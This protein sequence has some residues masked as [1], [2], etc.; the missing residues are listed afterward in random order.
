MLTSRRTLVAALV[1]LAVG[2]AGLPA[3]ASADTSSR[4]VQHKLCVKIFDATKRLLENLT[5]RIT[6]AESVDLNLNA[7]TMDER[8][9]VYVDLDGMAELKF[10]RKHPRIEAKMAEM[11]GNQ[12][13][14]N[15]PLC[16]DFT[17][18][19]VEEISEQQYHV[20]F[21][22]GLVLVLEEFLSKLVH[23]GAN[24]V[25]TITMVGIGN[26]LVSFLDGI[27]SVAL[28]S[29]LDKGFR[30]LTRVILSLAGVE[31]YDAFRELKPD[32]QGDQQGGSM[33]GAVLAHLGLSLV[34][35]VT[36]VGMNM[37]GMSVGAMVGVALS[38]SVGATIGAVV[39]AAGFVL[40]G[41]VV[42][43]KLAV[44]LPM[45]YRLARIK[46]LHKKRVESDNPVKIAYYSSKIEKYEGKILKR[47]SLEMRTDKFSFLQEFMQQL[48]KTEPKEREALVPLWRKLQAKLRF[49]VVEHSDRLA[50]R[51]LG[52]LTEAMN[53]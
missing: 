53:P 15:G 12:M 37:A 2:I 36:H 22:L 28:A 17:V 49:E 7:V 11:V 13:Q 50:E 40:V 47:V 29:S 18:T 44:D 6:E 42:Y 4:E 32:R 20:E 31:A 16:I 43:R 48:G 25:G 33:T 52:Q 1:A 39:G 5:A 35:G 46:R 24:I 41:N 21:K 8:H 45:K 51:M 10:D 19:G 38:P 9:R 27:D 3:S 14:T 26:D 30:D 34:K 23:F